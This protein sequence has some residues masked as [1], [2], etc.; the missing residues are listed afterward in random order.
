MSIRDFVIFVEALSAG[1]L[2]VVLIFHVTNYQ[3]SKF[4]NELWELRDELA[5][6]LLL[7][8][9]KWSPRAEILL[10]LVETYIRF[11]PR[12]SFVD[13]QLA[14]R[15]LKDQ[16]IPDPVDDILGPQVD[17]TGRQRMASYLDRLITAC[18]H[19]MYTGVPIW[20]GSMGMVGVARHSLS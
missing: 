15:A 19:H 3:H 8:R 13:V 20:L 10:R 2:P 9:L 16:D 1:L 5:D 17:P 14:I 11:A 7:G 12:H 6:D 4:R 18:T